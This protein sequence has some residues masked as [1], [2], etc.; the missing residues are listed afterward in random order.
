MLGSG[1]FGLILYLTIS[2]TLPKLGGTLMIALIICG[3]LLTG[4]LV[5]H[6]GWFGVEV[7]PINLSRAA[8]V[9]LLLLAGFLVSR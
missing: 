1:I 2:V 7:H 9:V 8:G 3:Q 6:F 5:D 4:L